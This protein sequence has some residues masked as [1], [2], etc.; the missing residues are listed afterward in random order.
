MSTNS[1]S[2]SLPTIK[3]HCD[4]KGGSLAALM[5]KN[6]LLTLLTL[7]IYSFWAKVRERQFRTS[8]YRI[9]NQLFAYHGTV[10][11]AFR[12]FMIV[13]GLFMILLILIV[14]SVMILGISQN[15]A[16]NFSVTF[17]SFLMPYA[18]F[19][20]LKYRLS[21]TRFANIAFSYRGTF[22]QYLKEVGVPTAIGVLF[23]IFCAP[24]ANVAAFNGQLNR[25]YYGDIPFKANAKA[26]PEL[27]RVH[28]VTL[29]LALP[30]LFMSRFW[31]Q[32]CLRRVTLNSLRLGDIRF[33]SKAT[34]ADFLSLFLG[35]LFL[36]A[37]SLGVALPWIKARNMRFQANT[38][39]MGGNTETL[40]AKAANPGKIGAFGDD[41][42]GGE[43][44]IDGFA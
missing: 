16:S 33:K 11:E 4:I 38:M 29:M 1:R 2:I 10:K 35:N 31:Y 41:M 23:G 3:L 18:L 7:G 6:G 32:T 14:G 22:S 20:A 9:G 26:T 34:G 28:W 44:L 19:A 25:C 15:A 27:W 13:S 30:T 8:S 5:L 17:V 37:I 43:M 40:I 21:R 12:G 42:T 39:I 24:L 36:L